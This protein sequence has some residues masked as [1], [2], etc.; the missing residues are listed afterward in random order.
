MLLCCIIF[1]SPFLIGRN[2][3]GTN[4]TSS[5]HLPHCQIGV[6]PQSTGLSISEFQPFSS[7]PT[8]PW[9]CTL[10]KVYSDLFYC[11]LHLISGFPAPLAPVLLMP[12]PLYKAQHQK[13][14]TSLKLRSFRVLKKILYLL[15]FLFF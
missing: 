14:A 7:N 4:F 13:S 15:M 5:I 9:A 12:T 11:T 6:L 3:E 2:L 10:T 8:C 1:P